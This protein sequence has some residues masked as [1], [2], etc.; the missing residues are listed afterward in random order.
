MPAV[1]DYIFGNGAFHER[2]RLTTQ[3]LAVLVASAPR[4]LGIAQLQKVTY[5]SARELSKLCE[6]L[7]EMGLLKSD[8]SA[9]GG[10][11][12]ACQPNEVTL[13]DVYRFVVSTQNSRQPPTDD[14]PEPI[15]QLLLDADLLVTQATMAINQGVAKQLRQFSL[16][17]LRVS[18]AAKPPVS[19]Q[20]IREALYDNE[21]DFEVNA[22]LVNSVFET[23][24]RKQK[25]K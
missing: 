3:V 11:C 10:W 2:F 8:T 24:K 20:A 25:A 16:D 6:G 21:Y 14:E 23:H 17:R 13:E 9:R 12:L 5:R 22:W 18:S 19:K 1:D 4:P 15:E 7:Q